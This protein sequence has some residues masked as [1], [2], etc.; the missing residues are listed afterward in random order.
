MYPTYRSTVLAAALAVPFCAAALS[1]AAQLSIAAKQVYQAAHVVPTNIAGVTTF[2]PP[3]RGFD[4]VHAGDTELALHGLPPRPDQRTDPAAYAAW[5]RAM[6]RLGNQATGPLRDMHVTS[7]NARHVG[8]PLS[9]PAGTP[10]T[11]SFSNWSGIVNTIPGLTSW[12]SQKSFS[13]VVSEFN[14][15]VAEQAFASG[16]GYVCDGGWDLEVSW[17]GI[18]GFSNGDVLQGGSYSGAY[19]SAGST[20]TYY[21]GWVEWFPSYPILCEFNVNPGDDMFVE[22]WDTSSTNGYVFVDDLTQ[23]VYQTVN[24]QPQTTP[25]LVGNS[26]EYIVERPCCLNGNNYPLANYVQDYWVNSYAY[27]FARSASG[28]PTNEFP[29]SVA[30]ST[31]IATMVNDQN[32]ENISSV[33]AAGKYGLF[34]FD[35]NCAY[36]GGCTP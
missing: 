4:A 20:S 6:G 11:I 2:R 21:C 5:A 12:D 3:P 35:E 27:T 15:P 23:G 16:G 22:T 26:A 13:Y 25:Y 7:R 9:G 8:A 33:S 28:K 10:S 14:V 31:Y 18:D 19:C 29:G 34:F 32:S 30:F 36:S 17:N 1:A 24:L